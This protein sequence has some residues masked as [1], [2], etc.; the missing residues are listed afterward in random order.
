ME[1]LIVSGSNSRNSGGVFVTIVE[2]GKNLLS[3]HNIELKYL[4]YNDEYTIKDSGS[5]PKNTL[6]SYEIIGPKKF[7]FSLDIFLK[8]SMIR[9]Q[10]IHTQSLW[11]FLSYAALRYSRIHKIPT[12][13][14]PHGMLDLYQLKTSFWKKRIIL[15]LYEKNNLNNAS[16]IHALNEAEYRSIRSLGIKKPIAIIPNGVDIPNLCNVKETPSWKNVN[17]KTLLFLSR[18]DPK[19]N[20]HS[21][22]SAWLK[23]DYLNHDWEL[24]IAG[25][26]K[27]VSYSKLLKDLAGNN[28]T[29][30]FIGGQYG[31]DKVN[32]FIHSDA[33]ILPSFSEGLPMAVLEAWSYKKYTLISDACNLNIG[34][35][36]DAAYRIETDEMS[37]ISSLNELF[38]TPHSKLIDVGLRA[39]DLV[40]SKFTWKKVSD[41]MLLL[42]KW[43]SGKC[44]KPDFVRL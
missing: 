27:D 35:E 15:Q 29:I 13:V 42:Y 37:L 8:I 20:I 1:V 3:N 22:I 9:P 28:A 24:V 30:K 44:S 40:A 2:T 39:F 14:S 4:M 7:G 33:F 16:C 41:D 11:M 34:F 21:L 10:I 5:Y 32:S 25:D 12:I 38:I 17:K 18:I 31:N 19:K 36:F 6:F 23:S 26:L 43:V